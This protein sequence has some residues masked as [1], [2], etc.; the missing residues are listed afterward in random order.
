MQSRR[1][2]L[3]IGAGAALSTVPLVGE[4]AP[5]RRRVLRIAHITD[6]HIQPER[7]AGLGFERCL[8]HAQSQRPDVIFMGGDLVMDSLNCDKDRLKAQWDLYQSV[9]RANT[10]LP[11]YTVLGNHDVWGWGNRQKYI[12][13]PLFGKRY[14]MQRLQMDRPYRSFDLNNWHFVL[15]DSTHRLPGNGYTARLNDEQIEWLE[16]DLARVPKGRPVL[17]L[18]HIP[19]VAACP[20]FHGD[21]EKTG[22]WQVPGAW[23]HLDVRRIKEL[24]R[25]YPQVNVC[26]SGHMHLVDHVEYVGVNYFCNG[27]CSAGWWG[28]PFQEFANG[29]AIVD[30]FSD[31]TAQNRYVT[32]GWVA[33]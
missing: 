25:K 21:N 7:K 19:I 10:N 5:A 29:Y 6:V 31:G 2:V 20:F 4:A 23:M 3:A 26:L 28:G 30:L 22:N 33:S 17:V 27:A 13:E 14:A 11:V 24:F 1:D 12:G 9:L 18:S 15:L 32:Y 8:E 16:D